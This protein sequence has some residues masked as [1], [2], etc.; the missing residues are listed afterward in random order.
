MVPAVLTD[1]CALVPA[2]LALGVCTGA[3]CIDRQV[4]TGAS[5]VDRLN[6]SVNKTVSEKHGGSCLHIPQWH[7]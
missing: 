6:S 5:F 2:V 7:G 3:S 4:C 1:S